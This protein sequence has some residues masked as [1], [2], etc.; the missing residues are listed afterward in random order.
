MEEF[1]WIGE[2]FVVVQSEESKK[3]IFIL[4]KSLDY[5]KAISSKFVQ[6]F[7]F[8]GTV[9][10]SKMDVRREED[11]QEE[12]NENKQDDEGIVIIWDATG[13]QQVPGTHFIKNC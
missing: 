7:K 11:D 4:L 2:Q 9:N 8:T 1:L 13:M 5:G 3:D 12:K 6:L 10:K